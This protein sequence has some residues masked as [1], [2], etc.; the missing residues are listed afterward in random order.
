MMKR[1][2]FLLILSAFSFIGLSAQNNVMWFKTTA[3]AYKTYNFAYDQWNEWTD[4]IKSDMNLK[5]DL[6][7]DKIT[8]YSP[9]VQIYRVITTADYYKDNSGGQT[10]KFDMIDQDGDRGQIRLRVETNGNS[11]VYVDFNNVS[12]VYN[13]VRIQ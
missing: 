1:F 5:I 6:S 9:E 10:V 4:W 12:W 13:V 2:L 3:Y 8:I 7:T 11:Q